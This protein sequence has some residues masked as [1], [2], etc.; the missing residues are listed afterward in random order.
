VIAGPDHTF[1][2]LWSHD[3]VQDRLE[4]LLASIGYLDVE[5]PS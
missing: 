2:P 3:L 4:R 1:R 5:G